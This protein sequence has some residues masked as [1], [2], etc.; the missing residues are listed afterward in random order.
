MAQEV[1]GLPGGRGGKG[2]KPAESNGFAAKLSA[3][4]D[5]GSRP[6]L[7][8]GAVG[9]K[10]TAPAFG[11]AVGVSERTVRHW[12]SSTGTLPD[13]ENLSDILE[14]LF[15]DERGLAE[16][17]RALH[18]AWDA[19]QRLKLERSSPLPAGLRV[20]LADDHLALDQ[21]GT[22]SDRDVASDAMVQQQHA[23]VR[24]LLDKLRAV[25]L[26]RGNQLTPAWDDLLPTL[27]CLIARLAGETASLP[28]D[29]AWL[30]QEG[31]SLGSLLEQHV[32]LRDHPEQGEAALTADLGRQLAD[33]VGAV[34]LLIR[35]FPSNRERD[36]QHA[37]F[38]EW[39]AMTPARAVRA[40][41]RGLLRPEDEALLDRMG[42]TA[43]RSGVQGNKA[44][45]SFIATM[46][47]LAL[48]GVTSLMLSGIANESPF[49]KRLSGFIVSA[50]APL[51]QLMQS[52]PADFAATL[53]FGMDLVR[54]PPALPSGPAPRRDLPEIEEVMRMILAGQAPP[55]EWVPFIMALDFQGEKEL[56]HLAPLAGLT[57]LKTLDLEGTGVQE[58]APLAGLTSLDTLSLNETG[59]TELAPLASLTRLEWLSL[60]QTVVTEL[61]PLAGLT[62]LGTLWL[63]HTGVTELAPLASLTRLE[64]LFLNQTGVTELAALAGLTKLQVLWLSRTGVTDLTPLARLFRL[65]ELELDGTGVTSLG[66][67][68]GLTSLHTLSLNETGVAELAPLA[69]LT[70][71]EKLWLNQTGVAELGPL[72]NLSRLETLWLNQTS[73]TEL[74]P[75]VGL[76]NL[77][78]YINGHTLRPAQ[79]EVRVPAG[80]RGRPPFPAGGS[81]GGAP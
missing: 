70:N 80:A 48:A 21:A 26:R 4:L 43:G 56:K 57:S 29:M 51:G 55:P 73:V 41:A 66:P 1:S 2:G 62:R 79:G 17:R 9:G 68:A 46:G 15:G 44:T 23:V 24:G 49:I 52:F 69:G 78:V 3:H 25:V 65:Q 67:L 81:G 16:E 33:S 6:G 11:K 13:A 28:A 71:L 12:R 38:W 74:S 60:M 36:A 47:N 8:P 30:Y 76:Q 61:A 31:L 40:C 42:R 19:A 22:D 34:A 20:T 63:N 37:M 59:V 64:E 58:L 53:R 50:E 14:V 45:G 72:A 77:T 32:H 5:S 7:K 54:D 10:W 27:E 39:D 35:A 18:E 75:L